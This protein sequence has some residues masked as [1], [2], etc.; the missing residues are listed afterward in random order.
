MKLELQGLAV[1]RGF[2]Q[3]ECWSTKNERIFCLPCE[4]WTLSRV[5]LFVTPMDC[6]PPGSSVDGVSQARILEWGCHFLL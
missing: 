1:L 2:N 4:S 5:R 6:S 3:C